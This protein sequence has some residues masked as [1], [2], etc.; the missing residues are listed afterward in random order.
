MSA[1]LALLERLRQHGVRARL[2]EPD[3][4]RLEAEREPPPDLIAAARAHKPELVEHLRRIARCGTACPDLVACSCGAVT[5]RPAGSTRCLACEDARPD[6]LGIRLGEQ[7]IAARVVSWP[8]PWEAV[9]EYEVIWCGRPVRVRALV[10]R[11]S[12]HV[13]RVVQ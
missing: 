12:P 2:V 9:V 7:W 5:W 1:A 11:D 4:V 13:R 8:R 6:E 10:D 3:R